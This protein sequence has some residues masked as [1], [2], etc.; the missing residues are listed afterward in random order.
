MFGCE[1]KVL[2][3]NAKLL[4]SCQL[5]TTQTKANC[6]SQNRPRAQ[7]KPILVHGAKR[8]AR[9]NRKSHSRSSA[10]AALTK[11]QELIT[12]NCSS[13]RYFLMPASRSRLH[14]P[15]P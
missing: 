4:L 2:D 1:H 12:K 15:W 14:A 5:K 9:S 7:S 11:N 3:A 8:D 6:P 13:A 10:A